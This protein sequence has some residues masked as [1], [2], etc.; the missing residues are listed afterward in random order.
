MYEYTQL[1]SEFS[2]V[3]LFEIGYGTAIRAYEPGAYVRSHTTIIAVLNKATVQVGFWEPEED[4]EGVAQ[5]SLQ[6]TLSFRCDAA[7][8]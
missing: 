7:S 5:A 1:S 2:R 8:Q 6:M 3:S 4:E